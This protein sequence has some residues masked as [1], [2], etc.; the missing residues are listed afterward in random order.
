M[1]KTIALFLV[2]ALLGI[3]LIVSCSDDP[4]EEKKT[5]DKP[6]TEVVK[7]KV[8]FDSDGRPFKDGTTAAKVVEV[9][10]DKTVG[11]NWPE[12]DEENIGT[13]ELQGW[14]D[15][16]TQVTRTTPITKDVTL[17]AKFEAALF[18]FDTVARTATH[19]NFVITVSAGG[20]HGNWDYAPGVNG[21]PDRNNNKELG[22]NKFTITNGGIQYRFPVTVNFDYKDY[23]FVDVEYTAS[24]V[25]NVTPKQYDTAN[26]YAYYA[27]GI[28]NTADD[29]KKIATWELRK[30][31][32]TEAGGI[33]FAI[34]KYNA[35]TEDTTIQFTRI[36]FKQKTRYTVKFDPDGGSAVPDTYLVDGTTIADHLPDST[37]AGKIFAGWLYKTT[38]GTHVAGDPVGSGDVVSSAY[39]GITFKAFW[40]DAITVAPIN[41]T[42]T[43]VSTD[44]K[45]YSGGGAQAN[46]LNVEALA[47]D[48]ATKGYKVSGL[49]WQW[50]YVTFKVDIPAG[51]TLA[52]Y[53]TVTFDIG[54]ND[55]KDCHLAAAPATGDN[56][57][58]T[59]FSQSTYLFNE[60][61]V[62]A[63]LSTR[64]NTTM[65]IP[66][67]KPKASGLTGTIE[68]A[69]V[70]EAGNAAGVYY[71]ISNIKFE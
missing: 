34:Q 45:L 6:G 50:R 9:E 18:T 47:G 43:D 64:D 14:Y 5:D 52:H 48:R 67:I 7:Y 40:L 22:D 55:W 23:D 71:E 16:A 46:D 54:H 21:A 12:I 13:D 66:I 20:K 8:T 29:E 70:I 51:A 63:K 32:A 30:A 24:Q 28:S 69:I 44:I 4:K 2:A 37:R 42:F 35:A 31:V 60:K 59:T 39:D 65:T 26:D 58:N 62:S 25:N 33:G 15:G 41:I 3:G 1:K 19:T 57:F 49:N 53:D 17:K 38:V 61:G 68:F 11:S 10:K 36:T 56:A 27:G